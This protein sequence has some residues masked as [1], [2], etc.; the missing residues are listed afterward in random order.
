MRGHIYPPR[1]GVGLRGT[2]SVGEEVGA[3]PL[4]EEGRVADVGGGGAA[5]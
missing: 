4:E 2:S 3:S 1:G 5:S